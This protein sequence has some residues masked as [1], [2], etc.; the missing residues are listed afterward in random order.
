MVGALYAIAF[1]FPF[2][3][4]VDS[5]RPVLAMLALALAQGGSVGI[6]FGVQGVVLSE[7]F[8]T[9]SCS[10]P[11]AATAAR[12]SAVSSRRSSSAASRR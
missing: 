10:A 3:V 7:L 5:G 1:A 9:A 6:M 12:P 4:L 8:S 11:R 2:F